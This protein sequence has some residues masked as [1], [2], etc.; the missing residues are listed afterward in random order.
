MARVLP[1]RRPDSEV[2]PDRANHGPP[3]R[4]AGAIVCVGISAVLVFAGAT[5]DTRLNVPPT[6]AYVTAFVFTMAALRLLQLGV[7]P[8]SEGN[9]FAA[10]ILAGLAM[11]GG[12]IAIGPGVRVCTGGVSAGG[13]MVSEGLACRIPFGLGAVVTSV[14]AVWVGGRWLRARGELSDNGD[15]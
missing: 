10:L 6:I 7:R 14:L 11:I 8:R 3:A 1:D 12:W 2:V 9:G 4:I 5:R 15:A 13:M